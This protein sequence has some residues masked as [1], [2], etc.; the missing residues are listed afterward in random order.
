MINLMYLIFIAMLAMNMSKEV[1]SAFG[2]MNVKLEGGNATITQKN[3]NAFKSLATKAIDQ[4]A[5][6]ASLKKKADRVKEL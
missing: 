4:S 3:D 2:Y 6:Y 5:K 1:L